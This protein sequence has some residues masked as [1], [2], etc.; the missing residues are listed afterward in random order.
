[1]KELMEHAGIAQKSYQPCVSHYDVVTKGTYSTI[2]DKISHTNSFI[3]YLDPLVKE[4]L[5]LETV[6]FIKGCSTKLLAYS[7]IEVCRPLADGELTSSIDSR[8]HMDR[9]KRHCGDKIAYRDRK[10]QQFRILVYLSD[11]V[12]SIRP[13]VTHA[14]PE[15]GISE[16]QKH[17]LSPL[18]VVL[19]TDHHN[20]SYIHYCTPS[21]THVGG[22]RLC[23]PL[24]FT[25]DT[26]KT[27]IEDLKNIVG[28]FSK[29]FE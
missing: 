12:D 27:S 17:E 18:H 8:P 22:F 3:N 19:W 29:K 15:F 13:F 28:K 26:S 6:Q 14:I 20:S 25:V 9:T 24:D 1:M 2:S 4:I 5:S 7:S 10:V 21:T 16:P 11:S 23:V